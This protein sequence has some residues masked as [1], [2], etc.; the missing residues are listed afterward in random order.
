V[1]GKKLHLR[2]I[3]L[4]IVVVLLYVFVDRVFGGRSSSIIV[5]S[6]TVL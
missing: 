3:T 1:V 6:T 5:S 2:A 4:C